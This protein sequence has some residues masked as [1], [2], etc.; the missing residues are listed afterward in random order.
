MQIAEWKFDGDNALFIAFLTHAVNAFFLIVS[1]K[2][3]K[4][5]L[6][7]FTFVSFALLATCYAD[8]MERG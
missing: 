3:F 4:G 1:M 5:S 6:K 7:G 8:H 2:E